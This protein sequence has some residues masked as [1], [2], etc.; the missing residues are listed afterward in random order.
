MVYLDP[1]KG[2][3]AD[4]TGEDPLVAEYAANFETLFDMAMPEDESITFIR[5]VADEMSG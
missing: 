3:V 2:D 4:I 1:G 5:A